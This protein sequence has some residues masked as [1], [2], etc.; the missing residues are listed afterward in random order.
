[1][2]SIPFQPE[3]NVT[4]SD[5]KLPL[6]SGLVHEPLPSAVTLFVEHGCCL[7]WHFPASA[8]EGWQSR[9]GKEYKVKYWNASAALLPSISGFRRKLVGTISDKIKMM[10]EE[11]QTSILEMLLIN[12]LA[13][14]SS[15]F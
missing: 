5:L 11:I 13:R 6:S 7:Q 12:H 8:A 10:S 9:F 4:D 2:L 14:F 1:M 3:G 15:N